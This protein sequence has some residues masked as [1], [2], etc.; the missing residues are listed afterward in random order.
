MEAIAIIITL[1]LH[2]AIVITVI[3]MEMVMMKI[4]DDR[5]NNSDDDDDGDCG[6]GDD[7]IA[8]T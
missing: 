3:N 4:T 1:S 6:G 7:N 5:N 2:Y 8:N